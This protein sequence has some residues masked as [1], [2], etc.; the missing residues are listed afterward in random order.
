MEM[1]GCQ[2]FRMRNGYFEQVTGGLGVVTPTGCL[3][4]LDRRERKRRILPD[5]L[6]IELKGLHELPGVEMTFCLHE[7]LNRFRFTTCNG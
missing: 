4:G 6:A 2:R 1:F 7:S 3:S 5:R